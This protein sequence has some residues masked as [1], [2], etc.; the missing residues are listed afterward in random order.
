MSPD[1]ISTGPASTDKDTPIAAVIRAVLAS[2]FLKLK[3]VFIAV[4]LSGLGLDFRRF[5]MQKK[6]TSK[7]IQKSLSYIFISVLR[8]PLTVKFS[9]SFSLEQAWSKKAKK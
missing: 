4:F 6:P 2:S 7:I 9:D 3:A 8:Y 5:C 1:P